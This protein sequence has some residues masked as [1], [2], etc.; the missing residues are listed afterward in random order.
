M[1][2]ARAVATSGAEAADAPPRLL[3]FDPAAPVPVVRFSG[4]QASF[5][6]PRLASPRT[7]RQAA[8][9]LAHEHLQ[10][11]LRGGELWVMAKHG[12]VGKRYGEPPLAKRKPHGIT[13]EPLA[14]SSQAW[15]TG[16]E[17]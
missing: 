17:D 12:G 1:T 11:A 14:G 9:D 6:S 2:A 15:R 8:R 7:E 10:A 16:P 3:P 5:A 13:S 4:T